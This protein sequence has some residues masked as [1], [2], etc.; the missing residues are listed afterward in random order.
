MTKIT[1]AALFFL[2]AGIF[3]SVSILSAYQVL[4]A[5]PLAYYIFIAIR[6]KNVQLP[7]SAYWLIAFSIIALISLVI[8]YNIVPNPSKNF[9]KLKYFLYGFGGILVFR[10]WQNEATDKAK[11]IITYTFFLGVIVAGLY[12][13]Y[14]VLINGRHRV[15][16][17]TNTMR[18]GYGSAM[19]LLT[20]LSALLHRDKIKGWFDAK[21]GVVAFAIGL[22]GMYLSY[23]RGG[24][25]G[26]LF[27]LPFVFYF[28]RPK[29][30]YYLGGIALLCGLSL[31]AIYSSSTLRFKIRGFSSNKSSDTQR[32]SQWQ[33]GL[34]AT[35]EKPFL[36]WGYSNFHTQLKRIK[37]ENDLANKEYDDAH[38]HNLFLE[39]SSGTGIIGLLL[40][41]GWLITWA[42]E[43]WS[44]G[45]LVRAM[46][47]PFGVSFVISSQFEVTFDANNASMIF[48]LYALSSS[49]A[50]AKSTQA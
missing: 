38:S 5:I 33:A 32:L 43:A 31:V 45:G 47:I 1:N 42:Y 27:G 21:W 18:Y 30:G 48:F 15:K 28:Y 2:A 8:N 17:L 49:L 37:V 13:A 29:V 39:I 9:G 44:A 3:T 46:V 16:G 36:G 6:E 10:Y 40:F 22:L 25:L 23:T 19:I 11:K 35:K 12:G 41:L 4:F 34:I 50:E 24:F 26:F 7:K 20:F 14:E